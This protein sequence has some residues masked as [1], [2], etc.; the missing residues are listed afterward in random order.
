MFVA[1]TVD[2]AAGRD[3]FVSNV[4][5]DDRNTGA[6]MRPIVPQ[7][8]PVRTIAKALRLARPA[9][10]IILDN[11]TEPYHETISLVGSH[12]SGGVLGPLVIEGHGALL[13]GTVPIPAGDWQQYAGDVY[14]YQPKQ[15]GHQQLFLAGR[16]AAQRPTSP[17]KPSPAA[18]EP[19]EWCYWRGE[20]YFR[21]EPVRQPEDYRPSCCGLPGASRCTT[22]ATS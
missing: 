10:R 2:A 20:I 22:C 16:Q 1:A 12:N 11:T 9:D 5:G 13:D 21:T 7:G 4:A 14:T 19:L 18:L 8:G 17:D 15:M 6:A 3:I